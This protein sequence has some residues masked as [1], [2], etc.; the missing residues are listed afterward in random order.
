M[1]WVHYIPV[2]HDCS[3]LVKKIE[4]LRD[5]P[6]IAEAIGVQGQKVALSMTYEKEVN[7]AVGVLMK[8]FYNL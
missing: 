4:F 3:D 5:N 2:A 6:V 1:P 8:A 7:L